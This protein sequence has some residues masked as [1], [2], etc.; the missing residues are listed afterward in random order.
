MSVVLPLS[1]GASPSVLA[2]EN[3]LAVDAQ[4]KGAHES[5]VFAPAHTSLLCLQ[6]AVYPIQVWQRRTLS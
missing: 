2:G 5:M 1:W 6:N 3:R 4:T